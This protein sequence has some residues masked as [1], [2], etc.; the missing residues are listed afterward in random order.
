MGAKC[1]FQKFVGA[2]APPVP[3]LTH[4][5]NAVSPPAP[6]ISILCYKDI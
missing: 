3:M 4:P 5:L 1:I 2:M 6:D